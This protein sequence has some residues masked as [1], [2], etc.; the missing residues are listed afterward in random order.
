MKDC[1]RSFE[2]IV[3]ACAHD[4]T[5]RWWDIVGPVTEEDLTDEAE[6]R[7]RRCLAEDI[8]NGH[9]NHETD[10]SSAT[11]WWGVPGTDRGQ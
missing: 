2:T 6:D 3:R 11:G 5:V 7:I 9:L 10:E 8:T 1:T 4:V